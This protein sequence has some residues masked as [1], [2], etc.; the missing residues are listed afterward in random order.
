MMGFQLDTLLAALQ[1]AEQLL[2]LP[3]NNPDPDAI[4]SAVALKTLVEQQSE[5]TCQ[6]AYKGIIG[7]PENR[8]LVRYL[9]KP[10]RRLTAQDLRQSWPVALVDSQPGIGNSALNNGTVARVIIDHHPLSDEAKTAVFVDVR[11]SIGATATILTEYLQAV[12]ME[13]ATPLATALFYGI[14]TD[15]LG[16]VRG[17]TAADIAAYLYL[18]PLIDVNALIAIENAQVSPAYFRELNDTVQAARVYGDVVIAYIGSM[19][20]PELAGE[21]ADLL[22]RLEGMQWSICMGIYDDQV[23]LSVRNRRRR[24]GAGQLARAV[25]GQDGT[26]GGH[27]MMAGGQIP[28][29]GRDAAQMAQELLLRVL[30]Y[31]KVAPDTSGIPLL[32]HSPEKTHAMLSLP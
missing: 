9:Q 1:G 25:V 17:A 18:Q 15:T 14:K 10:L 28:L 12:G 30:D 3:H 6:I 8:A 5:M 11:P 13:P 7:R 29:E 32:S 26:A 4:A 31:F 27:G 19:E 20:Y 2:I 22:L 21:M 16:L 24:G 23:I